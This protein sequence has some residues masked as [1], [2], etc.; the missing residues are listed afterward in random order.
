MR[1]I[2]AAAG[3]LA[4][5]G[6]AASAWAGPWPDGEKVAVVL[7]YDD[8]LPS[9]LDIAL[10]A[11]DAAGLKGTFFVTGTGLKPDTIARWRAAAAEGHELGNHTVFHACPRAVYPAPERNT[12]ES[13]TVEAMLTEI[14]VM[15][16]MLTA[17]DGKPTHTMA[18]PCGAHMAGG[19]DYLPALRK[20]GTVKYDRGVGGTPG[21]P[22]DVPS[23]WFAGN[24]TAA[25]MIKAVEEAEK[26]GGM[27]VFGFHGV[28]GD[29]L[30]TS[31]EAH[32]G[33]LAWL[34]AHKSTVWVAPFAT[35]MD[36]AAKK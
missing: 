27:I 21:D 36:A 25:D 23:V 20:S 31:A 2:V 34:K 6:L 18:T 35:V 30:T 32:A 26:T 14:A 33:F 22:L 17:V 28:G 3:V 11:L 8:A 29:Y 4:A 9:Q 1:M 24:A 5:A 13:Y 7:T 19:T 16:T 12:S 10:P 15:N